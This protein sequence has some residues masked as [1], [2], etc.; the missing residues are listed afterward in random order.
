M[1]GFAITHQTCMRLLQWAYR[2]HPNKSKNWVNNKYWLTVGQDH[3]VF[4]ES[5]DSYLAKHSK[6]AI[7]RHIKVKGNKSPFDGDT[8]Y[9]V[10]RMGKHPELKNSIAKLLKKQN[11]KCNLCGLTFQEG[12]I[13]E[14]DHIIPKSTGGKIKDNLQLLHK[15]CH[16]TKTRYDLKAL[17]QYKA[18]K[19]GKKLAKGTHKE[20]GKRGAV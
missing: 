15:H 1:F 20:P 3:W 17:E 4:G 7:K 2:R 13:I 19:L 6:I 11:G 8:L 18:L 5:K 12:E 9:W 10:K 14:I 16:D